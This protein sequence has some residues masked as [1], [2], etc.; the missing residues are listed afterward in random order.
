[1]ADRYIWWLA[2]FDDLLT[3]NL[4]SQGKIDDNCYR[5]L[6]QITGFGKVHIIQMISIYMKSERFWN[7]GMRR[8]LKAI[9]L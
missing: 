6:Q 5:F 2:I 9:S 7:T 3:F 1:M 4:L 8:I